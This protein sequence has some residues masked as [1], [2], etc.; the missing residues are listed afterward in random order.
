MPDAK[1]IVCLV[2]DRLHSGFVGAY[3]NTWISTPEVDRLAAESFLFERACIDSPRLDELYRSYWQGWHSV[4]NRLIAGARF[5]RNLP[6]QLAAAGYTTALVSDEPAVSRLA[7]SEAFATRDE[8]DLAMTEDVAESIGETHLAR[9][10]A[11]AAERLIEMRPPFFLWLHTGSLGQTW[12]APLEF[13]D[14]YRDADDPPS[15][16]SAA[17][18]CRQLRRDFDP[19]ELLGI[20]HSYAGQVT[21]L[22]LCVGSLIEAL[23][24]GSF[25]NDTLFVLVSARGFPLGEHGRVGP[26]DEALYCELTQIPWL[27]RFPD[28]LGQSERTHA[29][30]Q[31]ADL[32]AT[33]VDWLGLPTESSHH[34]AAGQSLLPLVSGASAAVRDRATI[35]AAPDERAIVTPA[36]YMRQSGV[37]ARCEL[38][39][40]PDDRFE[41]N[42][43]ASRCPECVEQLQEAFAQFQQSCQSPESTDM[44]PLPEAL[45]F[46]IE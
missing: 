3:G 21:L 10:F 19:D 6:R 14:Q 36:W 38:F 4:A 18:P 34:I 45:T 31:P 24:E 15:P 9:F 30:V 46:G 16:E 23:S 29:L 42:E 44:P 27:L 8:L 39:V 22:D 37:S 20:M 1:N 43:V 26:I 7:L 35:I 12:D 25:A 2:V 28:G 40:K 11:A 33:L 32:F 41:V 5:E 13:R 17:V